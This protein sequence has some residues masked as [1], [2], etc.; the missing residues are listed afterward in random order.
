M[1]QAEE[2]LTLFD[3]A[4]RSKAV[5]E[6]SEYIA[7]FDDPD[8]VPAEAFIRRGVLYCE[9]EMYDE[10][11]EDYNCA[12]DASDSDDRIR[13][14]VG[15]AQAYYAKRDDEAAL[16][17]CRS[18]TVLYNSSKELGDYT[19]EEEN[20]D[21]FSAYFL[22]A[23]IYEKRGEL[24]KTSDCYQNA[25]KFADA[26]NKSIACAYYG[27]FLLDNGRKRHAADEFMEALKFGKYCDLTELGDR[28]IEE[29]TD[30]VVETKSEDG[31]FAE[32]AQ[33]CGYAL[34]CQ[35]A[36]ARLYRDEHG[37]IEDF[38][39]SEIS[40]YLGLL[41][42]K[43]ELHAKRAEMFVSIASPDKARKDYSQ[44]SKACDKFEQLEK[45]LKKKGGI[46][47]GKAALYD[48][49]RVPLIRNASA[50]FRGQ[51]EARKEILD[52][53]MTSRIFALDDIEDM[54]VRTELPQIAWV[55]G[56]IGK[57]SEEPARIS[58]ETSNRSSD[59]EKGTELSSTAKQ[60]QEQ[61]EIH[62]QGLAELCDMLFGGAA[63]TVENKSKKTSKKTSVMRNNGRTKK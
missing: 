52:S 48:K 13:A 22:M 24:Q 56:I 8:E 30:I 28:S 35:N 19:E 2:N 7:L 10:A 26:E 39:C 6:I 50:F 14:L 20:I 58:E 31:F 33:V 60:M 45:L 18:V 27:N 40:E 47:E 61:E 63:D 36:I 17:C 46:A 43:I 5:N 44:M 55:D 41:L 62:A 53:N 1:Q 23:Q 11:I 21:I 49:V 16:N 59:F 38:S 12:L 32:T 4:E 37:R 25:E 15:M 29:I 42:T 3:C 54:K 34:D 9:L 51:T 57:V